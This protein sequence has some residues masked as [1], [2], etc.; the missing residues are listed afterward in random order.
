MED[1][2]YGNLNKNLQC[3]MGKIVTSEEL[4]KFLW[5]KDMD[6]DIL[7]LPNLSGRDVMS[8]TR[9]DTAKIFPY[10]KIPQSDEDFN[11]YISMEYGVVR[12]QIASRSSNIGKYYKQP[13]FLV[14]IIVPQILE[15]T[16][17]GSRLLALEQCIE[18]IF[19]GQEL[20]AIG[21]CYVGDSQPLSCP[22]GYLGR[23][24]PLIFADTN[25]VSWN[26]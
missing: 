19:H 6:K 4:V 1:I 9:G 18:N 24:V 16:A 2:I 25:E 5:Y 12:R 26:G 17:N 21:Q 11:C 3:I 15:V 8:L 7:S 20:K 23:V 14:Y 10:K 13:S 22:D